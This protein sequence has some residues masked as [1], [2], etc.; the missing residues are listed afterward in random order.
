[1][2][3]PSPRME[4]VGFRVVSKRRLPDGSAWL[5]QYR[6]CEKLASSEENSV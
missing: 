3:R 4:G 1:M 5:N 2:R 6:V